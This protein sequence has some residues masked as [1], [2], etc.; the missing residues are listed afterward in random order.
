MTSMKKLIIV[1]LMLFVA[2]SFSLSQNVGISDTLF[3]PDQSSVLELRSNEKGFLLPRMSAVERISIV[4]PANGLMVF[5]TDSGCVFFYNDPTTSWLNMCNMAVTPSAPGSGTTLIFPDGISG[6]TPVTINTLNTTPYTVPAGKN[7]YITSLYSGGSYTFSIN[8]NIVY[9]GFTNFGSQDRIL[10]LTNPLI[11]GE[12]HVVSGS[13]NSIT[14]NGFLVDA[15]IQPLTLGNLSSVNYT[16]PSGK[17]LVIMNCYSLSSNANLNI[18]GIRVYYGYSNW[19]DNTNQYTQL[20]LVLLAAP[21]DIISS[22]ENSFIINGY[23][24][25][26]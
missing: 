1:L 2:I 11:A 25:N 21:G 17:I 10:N 23:L 16:V 24:M 22:N 7:L 6:I 8:N 4:S 18:N 9:R 26:E 19:G 3:T 5:D 13:D 20:G 15:H 12:T 14:I